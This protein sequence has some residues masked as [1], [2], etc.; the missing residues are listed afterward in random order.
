MKGIN[1]YNSVL[2]NF[3]L[4]ESSNEISSIKNKINIDTNALNQYNL[5]PETKNIGE[6]NFPI[7]F[8]IINDKLKNL[9]LQYSNS[10]ISSEYEISFGKSCLCIRWIYDPLKIYFYNYDDNSNSF[11][12]LGIFELF[13]DFWRDIYNRHFT[14]KSFVLE[15]CN[16]EKRN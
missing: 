9:I 14:K 2:K 4:L 13:L 11:N 5:L 12:L 8:V 1:T 16:F 15:M 3:Q 10:G 7:N 6:F